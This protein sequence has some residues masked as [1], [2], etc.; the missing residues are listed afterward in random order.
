MRKLELGRLV[1][2]LRSE[3]SYVHRHPNR[4]RAQPRRAGHLHDRLPRF[5]RSARESA[6]IQCGEPDTSPPPARRQERGG[7]EDEPTT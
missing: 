7:E 6:R 2:S 5:P 4:E 3:A 1:D